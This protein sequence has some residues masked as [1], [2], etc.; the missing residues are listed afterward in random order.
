MVGLGTWMD[1]LRVLQAMGIGVGALVATAASMM[2]RNRLKNR[3]SRF[4][5][6]LNW[7]VNLFLFQFSSSRRSNS[8]SR[9]KGVKM[10]ESV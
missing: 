5:A 10:N 4:Q 7:R 3:F 9:A 6:R 8:P 2:M 1:M